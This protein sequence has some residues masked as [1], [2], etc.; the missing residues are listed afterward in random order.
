MQWLD[1]SCLPTKPGFGHGCHC[2]ASVLKSFSF[3]LLSFPLL[4]CQCKLY[5]SARCHTLLLFLPPPYH[6]SCTHLRPV[7]P[8]NTHHQSTSLLLLPQQKDPEE[9]SILKK[10]LNT[11]HRLQTNYFL[12]SYSYPVLTSS[13]LSLSYLKSQI[14]FVTLHCKK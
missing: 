5:I 7:T 3:Y 4:P 9:H 14:N 1:G 8:T 6:F 12:N 11:T 13:L 2:G 10:V